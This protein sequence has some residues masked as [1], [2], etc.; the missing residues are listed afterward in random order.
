M[1]HDQLRVLMEHGE[2]MGCINMS[3]FTALVQEL[4]LDDDEL[5][6]LYEQIEGRGIELTD[7]CGLPEVDGV[8][9]R[10]RRGRR[11]DDRLA[12][13]L[14]QRGRALSAPDRR[15]GGRAREGDRA[16]RQAREGPHGQLEPPSRRVDR[17]EV[18]GP[19]PAADRPD[20]GRDHRPD[21]R[22]REVRLAP[23]LQVLDV[24]DLVDP[25]GGAARR[26][27]QVAH[28][29]HPRPHRR[30]R[31]EDGARR[32]R[33]RVAARTRADGRR[34]R[35]EGEAEPQARAR[36]CALPRARLRASTSRSAKTATPR[37]AISSR[38]SRA[39][40]RR[41]SSSRS[42]TTRSTARSRRCRSASS[43]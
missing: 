38:R 12:A 36:R 30:A 34:G 28:D 41:R 13:A 25:P 32:A 29:P 10:E 11:D 23:R 1:S 16:R 39:T 9:L 27:E 20:P 18:P 37:S 15:R 42:A 26:R 19:R 6:G 43:S 8:D 4:E 40:S 5:N 7:D 14:P 2:E 3:A 31:A 22:G 35:R 24:C 33:A 21:P 17:E